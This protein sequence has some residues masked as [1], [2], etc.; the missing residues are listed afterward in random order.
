[1]NGGELSRAMYR[2]LIVVAAEGEPPHL[3][4]WPAASFLLACR[5]RYL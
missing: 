1:M 5:V 3:S 2:G 4:Y